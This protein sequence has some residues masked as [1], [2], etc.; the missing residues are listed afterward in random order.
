MKIKLAISMF[1]FASAVLFA[2]QS[3]AKTVTI[4]ASSQD[5]TSYFRAQVN[6]LVDGDS[7]VLAPGNH[8][9]SGYIDIWFNS[10]SISGAGGAV[11][12][13]ISGTTSGLT[14]HGSHNTIDQIEIDGGG[15]GTHGP[16]MAVLNGTGNRVTNSKFH[17]S[18]DDTG[19][20]FDHTSL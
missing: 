8:Y 13:K 3:P 7:L 5:Q 17:N 2:P 11:V 15:S 18:G 9:I 20:L 12:R 1:S 19:L 16:C 6:S 10:G 14:V 4:A